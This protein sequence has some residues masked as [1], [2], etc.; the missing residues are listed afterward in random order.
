[1]HTV[2]PHLI[3]E[4]AAD[5]IDFYKRAFN[6]TELSRLPGPNGR[7]MHTMIRIGESTV[8]LVDEMP[9]WGALGPR[10][11]K[12]SPFAIDLYV[13]DVDAVVA[14]RYVPAQRRRCRSATCSGA[15]ATAI[16]RIR[17]AI[18]GRSRP[19][20]TTWRRRHAKGDAADAYVYAAAHDALRRLGACWNDDAARL[21]VE[22][23]IGT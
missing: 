17:S 16:S 8:M 15:I 11:L 23:A 5:A 2:T 19:T 18:A 20:C 12:G 21:A 9:E 14:Q 7:L 22:A 4:G 13:E 3:C 6:A 1:M 10:S